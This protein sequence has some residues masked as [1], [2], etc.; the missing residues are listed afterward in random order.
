M[1]IIILLI[2]AGI[3]I[4]L[5]SGSNGILGRATHAVDENKKAMAKE[6]VELA[7]SDFQTEF[8]DG[9]YVER[10][11]D[12]TKKEYIS[13]KLQAGVETTNFFAQ[14]SA[15]GKVNV[16]EGKDSF[17][18]EVVKGAIQED[19]SIK[20]DDVASGNLEENG[21]SDGTEGNGNLAEVA[22]L[23]NALARL[24][25]E[26][27]RQKDEIAQLRVEKIKTKS[28]ITVGSAASYEVNG[29]TVKVNLDT[30][31]SV[32]GNGLTIENG[33]IKVGKEIENVLVSASAYVNPAN[34]Q[35]SYQLWIYVNDSCVFSGGDRASGVTTGISTITHL[36]KVTEGDV[37]YLYDGN[38]SRGGTMN[39]NLLTVAEY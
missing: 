33:G 17:G 39:Q 14:A 21:G 3:S 1:T 10:T 18:T 11:N 15:E 29:N 27:N 2:L 5:I 23:K 7:L 8:F 22:E 26:V 4:A 37:I 24:E 38:T 31:E 20:W 25:E 32:V 19:A 30:V 36:I 35:C 13:E 6:Q 28:A 34:D 9:K 12:G 16:F